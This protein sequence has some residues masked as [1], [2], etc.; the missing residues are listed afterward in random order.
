MFHDYVHV[1][2]RKID[3]GRAQFLM[4]KALLGAAI[5]ITEERLRGSGRRGE[6]PGNQAI[7]DMY[8]ALHR[9]KYGAEFVIVA[10][11]NWGG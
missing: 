1:D 11:P 5:D 3:M 6:Q 9:R 8:C 2:G 7:F 10:D 4:D